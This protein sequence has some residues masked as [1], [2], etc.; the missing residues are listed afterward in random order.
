MFGYASIQG[1]RY[2]TSADAPCSLE[3]AQHADKVIPVGF[4]SMKVAPSL[5]DKYPCAS[6]D[7]I[8]NQDPENSICIWQ[9]KAL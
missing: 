8:S 3:L 7:I 6:R 9:S 4:T 2:I 5:E 1:W